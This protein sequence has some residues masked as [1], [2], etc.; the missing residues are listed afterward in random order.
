[1][2][3]NPLTGAVYH[4][5]A[6]HGDAAAHVKSRLRRGHAN[7]DT[8]AGPIENQRPAVAL[9]PFITRGVFNAEEKSV[10]VGA[11]AA[12]RRPGS[13]DMHSPLRMGGPDSDLAVL[14]TQALDS[15]GLE[16]DGHARVGRA[17]CEFPLA[18][19]MVG[20]NTHMGIR[21]RDFRRIWRNVRETDYRRLAVRLQLQYRVSLRGRWWNKWQPAVSI[22]NIILYQNF[23]VIMLVRFTHVQFRC[24]RLSADSNIACSRIYGNLRQTRAD[25]RSRVN[26]RQG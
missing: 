23:R 9:D 18:C 20:F 3:A 24:G 11:Q 2:I 25:R 10:L 17:D 1:V 21:F 8:V 5:A 4:Q 7:A 15:F 26:E 16:G 19:D 13:Q 22:S 14:Y 12:G 6:I